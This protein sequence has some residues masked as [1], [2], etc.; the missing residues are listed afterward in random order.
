MA[1]PKNRKPMGPPGHGGGMAPGEKAKDFKGTIKKLLAYMG[2]YKIAIIIVMI[3]AVGSTIFAVVGPKILGKA[4]TELFEGL[5]GKLS[6]TGSIRFGKIGRIL[7]FLLGLYIVS[8]I[9]ALIQ[10]WVMSGVSQKMS[11][12]MREDISKKINRMPLSYFET[13]TVGDVL[14]RITNDVDTLGQA[15]N[16]S[17]TQLIT[18]FCTLIGV[19]IMMLSISP[20]MTLITI[21][22]LPLSVTFVAL[23]VKKS[24][25]YFIAQQEYLGM[26]NGQI[27]ETFSGHNI[28][29]AFNRE[30]YDI[31]YDRYFAAFRDICCID[32]KEIA[33]IFHSSAGVSW[34]D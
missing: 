2:N 34:Y 6:G 23:I 29:K 4:T 14:S 24:Q 15:L 10:G 1:Q 19:L 33:E 17:I 5:V 32:C 13:N 11:Y 8:A 21:V 25:K 16:Q 26:I 28:V 7:L 27:E 31:D 18:S 12:K 9:F 30:A 22:I 20:L 3:F